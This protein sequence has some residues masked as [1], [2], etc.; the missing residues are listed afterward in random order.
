VGNPDIDGVPFAPPVPDLPTI[1]S[2]P[3]GLVLDRQPPA[4]NADK[5]AIGIRTGIDVLNL[6]LS[7]P[8]FEAFVHGET[9]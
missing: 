8:S 9:A 2:D 1:V 3:P 5:T 7:W 4:T 6:F